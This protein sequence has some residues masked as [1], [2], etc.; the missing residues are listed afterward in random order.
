MGAISARQFRLSIGAKR[1]LTLPSELLEQLQVPE[2]GELLVEVIGDHAMI[3][4]MVSMPRTQFPEELRR[5]FESRRGA[6]SS[7]IPLPQFLAAVG[8][9]APAQKTAAP[10]PQSLQ[11]PQE[12]LAK[13]TPNER[14]ALKGLSGAARAASR[15]D[16]ARGAR[17]RTA[18]AVGLAQSAAAKATFPKRKVSKLKPMEEARTAGS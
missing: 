13:L 6:H 15:T 16:T 7:D 4:P 18:P 5:A 8:Y 3:T 17:R 12:L 2:R 11:S 9:D 14:E 10:L 1:Q